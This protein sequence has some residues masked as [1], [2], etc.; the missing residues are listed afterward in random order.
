[1]IEEEL[2][3]G[4]ENENQGERMTERK[5]PQIAI[6]GAG[7]VGSLLGGILA[8][9][10]EDVTLIAKKP[11]V[12]AIQEVGLVIDG[13][14][15]NFTVDVP[16]AEELDFTPDIVFIAV[17]T[18]DVEKT[19]QQIKPMIGDVPVVM[20]QNGV[21]SAEIAASTFRKEN[22][23]SCTILWNAQFLKPGRVSYVRA[24]PCVI[25]SPFGRDKP[26]ITQ[27]QAL[28]N[29]V[30][31]TEISENILGV[32]WTKLLVNAM[33]NALDGMTGLSMG[34]YIQYRKLRDIGILIV[35]E[36][37]TLVEKAQIP[38]EPLPGIP[39]AYFRLIVSLPVPVASWILKVAMQSRGSDAILTSTLQSLRK[40][41]KT[42]IDYLNGEFVRLGQ[43]IDH[44]APYNAK[45]VAAVH[46]IEQTGQF[47][48]PQEL[49]AL[50]S[51]LRPTS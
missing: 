21:V 25:G 29:Q 42:E 28:L 30:A 33:S 40:G 6:V 16:A 11:H 4:M 18:Q 50:F 3:L 26:W 1:M 32:Q 9:N 24:H 34:E 27:I 49:P 5:R 17:K 22:I 31:R 12:Q 8:R 19:C 51:G 2:R 45:V 38:L 47:Y 37:V 7:A 36:A 48:S 46:E 43:Q 39:Q 15:G 14:A 10:G 44:P 35:K 20:M 23:I 41:K 13:V